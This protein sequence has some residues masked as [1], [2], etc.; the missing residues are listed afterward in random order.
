MTRYQLD[1]KAKA[2]ADAAVKASIISTDLHVAEGLAVAAA[3][4]IGSI[5]AWAIGIYTIIRFAHWLGS[6]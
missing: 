5:I 4:A 3:I 2:E 6:L 1:P